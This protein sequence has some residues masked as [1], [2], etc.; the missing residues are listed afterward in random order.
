M[1]TKT[2]FKRVAL[3]AVAAMGLGML[4]ATPSQ[5]AA[6]YTATA[7]LSTPSL[8]VVGTGTTSNAGLFYVDTTDDAGD[9]A[10]LF[11]TES[12]TVSVVL[13]NV[14]FASKYAIIII[15]T[16]AYQISFG[17][18]CIRDIILFVISSINEILTSTEM[19]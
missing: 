3:V 8:T 12:I 17:K 5:A 18:S 13:Q 11:S 6:T 19:V 16:K 2:T 10:A 1:S 7:T 4:V 15:H 14:P 9:A